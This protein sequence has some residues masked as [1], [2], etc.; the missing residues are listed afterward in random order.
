MNIY[1]KK[2]A[3]S[4]LLLFAFSFSLAEAN[5]EVYGQDSFQSK[6]SEQKTQFDHPAAV[7]FFVVDLKYNEIQ[8][9]QVCEIQP[10]VV[11]KF[12]GS[13]FVN[14]MRGAAAKN[15]CDY[16]STNIREQAKQANK[17]NVK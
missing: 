8:G 16:L 10:S 9:V 14:S 11:S 17:M 1:I 7:S 6:D 3:V 5:C 15:F 12:S 13:D 2:I 4:F